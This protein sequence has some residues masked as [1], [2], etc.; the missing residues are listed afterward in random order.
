[1]YK[2]KPE[3]RTA[4]EIIYDDLNKIADKNDT[5]FEYVIRDLY[6]YHFEGFRRE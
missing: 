1:M 4:I 3:Y 5:S 6:S 2:Y